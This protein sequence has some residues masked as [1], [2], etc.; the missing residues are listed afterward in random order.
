MYSGE[1][2][3]V[4]RLSPYAEIHVTGK[5]FLGIISSPIPLKNTGKRPECI[6]TCKGKRWTQDA[7]TS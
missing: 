6:E 5:G 2:D 4:K 7:L 3:S 1:F